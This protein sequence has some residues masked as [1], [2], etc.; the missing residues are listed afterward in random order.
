MIC[1][2][3]ASALVKRYVAE[4]GSEEVEKTIA[5]SE[6]TAT[7]MITRV[8]VASAFAKAVR[9]GALA[10][11][12]ADAA[13]R[14]F[15]R[16]WSDLIRLQVTEFMMERAALLAWDQGLRAYD[17]VQLAAA[18]TWR[19]SV[20]EPVAMVTFDQKLWTASSHVGLT[21]WPADLPG[22]IESWKNR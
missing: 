10:L 16:E 4:L 2:L 5:D 21:A 13:H 22:L 3:D 6:A 15:H 8:E 7:A 17:A 1:Y 20:D 19:E 9:F 18:V 11:E 12:D 14:T